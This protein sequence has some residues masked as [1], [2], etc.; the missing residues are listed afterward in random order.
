VTDGTRTRK[1]G[2]SGFDVFP[3]QNSKKRHLI[4]QTSK[5]KEDALLP[6]ISHSDKKGLHNCQPTA[7]LPPRCEC[8]KAKTQGP[9]LL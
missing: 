8:P 3:K 6:I 1:S 5:S 4:K 7:S 9:D 2:F